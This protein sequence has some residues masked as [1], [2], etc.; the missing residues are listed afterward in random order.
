LQKRGLDEEGAAEKTRGQPI[1]AGG[2][3]E[4]AM[5][6]ERLVLGGSGEDGIEWSCGQRSARPGGEE[7]GE[8]KD[9]EE[10]ARAKEQWGGRK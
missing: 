8:K 3:A 7:A 9:E 4:D 10:S 5:R 2:H 1:F 6:I